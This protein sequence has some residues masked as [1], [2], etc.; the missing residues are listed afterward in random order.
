MFHSVRTSVYRCSSASMLLRVTVRKAAMRPNVLIGCSRLYSSKQ[1]GA[2]NTTSTKTNQPTIDF[3]KLSRDEIRKLHEL[4]TAERLKTKNRSIALY[5]SSIAVVFLGLAYAAVPLY[6]AICARTGFGGIPI[7]D[8]RKFTDD[9]L[10]PVDIDKRLR[11][12]FTSEVSQILP[13][14]FV[15]QQREVYVLPGETALAFY[16]AKNN[17]DKDIIG[18]ATYSITPGD[19]AQYF[20]KIQCFCFEEQ[21]LAAGEEVDMPVFF[22]IDPEFATD[23]SMR[24]IDDIVLHY[25]FFRAHYGDG[26]AVSEAA[27]KGEAISPEEQQQMLANATILS[28]NDLKDE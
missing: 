5:F 15:P 8:R 12:S 11:V 18:M 2:S 24:N 16:K 3:S 9:K 21:K 13:W 7:T 22:F 20:N 6:R 19:A 27:S 23:P 10:V 28:P 25:T 26:S 14:K 1:S 17:S 4:K